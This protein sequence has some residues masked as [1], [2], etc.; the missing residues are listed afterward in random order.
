ML[1]R[2]LCDSNRFEEAL[3]AADA[4]LAMDAIVPEAA[5]RLRGW[6]ILLV[7]LLLPVAAA[8]AWEAGS[9]GLNPIPRLSARVTDLTQSLS[10]PEVALD[11]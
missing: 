7:A 9:D 10:A 6:L 11:L 4:G 2:I 5:A 1:A 3:A 8:Q